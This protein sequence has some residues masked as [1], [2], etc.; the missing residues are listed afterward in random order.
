MKESLKFHFSP[1]KPA[2]SLNFSLYPSENAI[3]SFDL[4]EACFSRLESTYKLIS[5]ISDTKSEFE[6]ESEK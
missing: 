3:D 2:E 5:E 4:I 6:K 1:T